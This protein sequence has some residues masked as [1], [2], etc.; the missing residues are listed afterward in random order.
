MGGRARWEHTILIV[1]TIVFWTLIFTQLYLDTSARSL[2]IEHL[3]VLMGL[4]MTL[5]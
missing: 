5:K 4:P 3:L 1:G 2:P